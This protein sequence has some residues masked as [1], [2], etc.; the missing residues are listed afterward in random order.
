MTDDRIDLLAASLSH[1]SA[2][3]QGLPNPL[4][5]GPTPCDEFDVT[6]LVDHMCR[7]VRV[8][9]D[10]ANGRSFEGDPEALTLPDDP[11]ATFAAM[12]NAIVDG[13]RANGIDRMVPSFA[14]GEIPGELSFG[15]TLMEYIVHGWD[16]ATA[17]GQPTDY[18]DPA[19]E[20]ALAAAHQFVLPEYRGPGFFGDIVP[21]PDDAPVLDQLVGFLGR[22]PSWTTPS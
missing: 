9:A 6:G 19:T 7:W 12:A 2:L 1:T 22:D 20:A 21:T 5:T 11:A 4:P 3:L 15:I 8:F 13:W 18:P 16:L 10:T 14:G 17:T